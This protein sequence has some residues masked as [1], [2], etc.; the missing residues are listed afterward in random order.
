MNA[1]IGVAK[2]SEVRKQG[3]KRISLGK[4]R[5]ATCKINL[6]LENKGKLKAQCR[7]QVGECICA[8]TSWN[9]PGK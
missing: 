4:K 8:Q 1:V 2:G 6:N 3:S 7:E 5:N 9:L